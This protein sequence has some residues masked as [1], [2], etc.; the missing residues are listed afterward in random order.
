MPVS[1]VL[2]DSRHSHL[3]NACAPLFFFTYSCSSTIHLPTY[4]DIFRGEY[5]L[6]PKLHT[7]H[8]MPCIYADRPNSS[9]KS[10]GYPAGRYNLK[11]GQK[12]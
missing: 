9:G 11:K 12:R 3:S 10:M 5:L 4:I 6:Q 8:T 7:T 1:H 2:W